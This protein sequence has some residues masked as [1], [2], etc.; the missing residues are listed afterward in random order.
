M[1]T[2]QLWER[3]EELETLGRLLGRDGDA[4]LVGRI[5]L[6]RGPPGAGKTS[7]LSATAREA[8]SRGMRVLSA[9][10]SP[11][12]REY[13]FAVVR[14]LLDP[15]VLN[16]G[17]GAQ[18]L[19]VGAARHAQRVFEPTGGKSGEGN[20]GASPYTAL[21]G[22][23]WLLSGIAQSQPVL[24]I[25]DDAHWC[26]SASG[27]FVAFLARRLDGVRLTLLLAQR[28]GDQP[29]DGW[30]SEIG[31]APGTQ[32]ILPRPLSPQAIT[33]IAETRLDG[34]VDEQL[35]HAC[36]Q[37]SG[38]NPFYVSAALDELAREAVPS[39]QR[40]ARLMSLGPESVLRSVLVRLARSPAGAVELAHAIAV[41][42][43]GAALADAAGLAGQS[44]TDARHVADGLAGLG[45]LTE[46]VHALSFAHPIVRNA[47]YRDLTSGARDS[48]HARAARM[49]I[50][51]RAPATQVAIHLLRSAPG[52]S[53]ALAVLVSAA[54]SALAQGAPQVAA[55]YLQRALEESLGRE[56]RADLLLELG[57]AEVQAGNPDAIDH[58][59]AGLHDVR[60]PDRRVQA[61][62]ALAHVL[63]AADR[64]A[65][66]VRILAELGDEI[67]E[68]HPQLAAQVF[69]E[70]VSLGDLIARPLVSARARRI[71]PGTGPAGLTHRA[72]EITASAGSALEAGRLAQRALA[73]G[74]LVTQGNAVFAFAASILIYAEAFASAERYL[75]Q[76]L[77]GAVATG[78]APAFVSASG[79]RALLN[80]RRGRLI[81]AE[82]DARAALDVCRLH[83]WKLWP[84]H[85]LTMLLEALLAR[86]QTA[87]AVA[88]LDEVLGSR[89]PPPDNHG[90]LLLD[91]RGRVRLA[92]GDTRGAVDDL[93]SAGE[94][95]DAWGL[96]NPT[97]AAWRSHAALGLAALGQQDRAVNLAD[98]EVALARAWASPRALG[99][100][101][102]SQALTY[103][104][105]RTIPLLREAC[106]TLARS[107][108]PVEHAQTLTELGCA[109]RRSNQRS[110]ARENLRVALDLAHA[111]GA[112]T[113]VQRAHTELTAAGARARMP[114]RTGVDALTPSERRIAHLAAQGQSNPT[115]A[116]GLFVTV[117][118]VE[119]HL[120]STYR[121]MNVTSRGQL[122]D[123]ICDPVHTASGEAPQE[124]PVPV[125]RAGQAG[126][127]DADLLD[128]AV[129]NLHDAA[130]F[131]DR[132][133]VPAVGADHERPGQRHPSPDGGE[134]RAGS[135]AAQR[136]PSLRGQDEHHSLAYSAPLGRAQRPQ[137]S[138]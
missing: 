12:E 110:H 101:L 32:V 106:A 29:G 113:L 93:L 132:N 131:S 64:A 44:V 97:V 89:E 66:G 34:D 126:T 7:L 72:A 54:R 82:A 95:L 121:K 68:S 48:M 114:L 42:G 109:L 4:G 41:L 55:R 136:E 16:A 111:T 13:S 83:D 14:Q 35:G 119:M 43:D 130:T 88:G 40:P 52:Q 56:D 23:F 51:V 118:T 76:A 80:A 116:Q 96:R 11:H 137:Q 59:T 17:E 125:A 135:D 128:R 36:W 105:E 27:D 63:A 18:P 67:A 124:H 98:S 75:D 2:E 19:F 33:A 138:R 46:D 117:K 71:A 92:L 69:S 50:G 62:L 8:Q 22:L 90:A 70:L 127:G 30:L 61:A 58:L 47:L 26:D 60:R 115:I 28:S 3:V 39:A 20:E 31:D 85:T 79:Q 6:V 73:D 102:R 38:G 99:V 104:D 57:L 45:I 133:E 25:V 15:V 65:E 123:A 94:R 91:A 49:L 5:G 120:T 1:Q 10:G 78:S 86:G 24:V 81:D 84:T 74:E 37:A 112:T 134:A 9:R 87:A 100:A 103:N 107:D 53:D 77:A 129:A 21:H 122:A 108:A